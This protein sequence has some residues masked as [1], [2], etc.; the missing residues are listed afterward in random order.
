MFTLGRK[1]IKKFLTIITVLAVIILSLPLIITLLLTNRGIQNYVVDQAAAEA[2]KFLGTEVSIG[3][4]EYRMPASISLHDVYLEDLETD[5]L[6]YVKDLT[7][8]LSISALARKRISI[9]D[10][11]VG[12]AKFYL[13]TD[14]TGRTNLQF[15]I[16]ALQDTTQ[17]EVPV[18][19]FDA[20]DVQLTDCSVHIDNT[21]VEPRSDGLFD[22]AHIHIS[23]IN[24]LA[25]L[26]HAAA[27]SVNFVLEKFSLREKSGIRVSQLGFKTILGNN[28]IALEDFKL[29]L[30]Q[31]EIN[32]PVA[33]I[34]LDSL[35]QLAHPSLLAANATARFS[36][37]RTQIYG[38]DLAP[39][40]PEA[41]NM[42][43]GLNI[44][45][46]MEYEH[47][48][49]DIRLIDINYGTNTNL[50]MRAKLLKIA[51]AI[52]TGGINGLNQIS[53]LAFINNV[54]TDR[55][56]IENTVSDLT[57]KPF[58][59][60][61][62]IE[63]FTKAN[64]KGAVM[65]TLKSTKY[66]GTL[67]TNAG[68]IK[69]NAHIGHN[70]DTDAVSIDGNVGLDNFDFA[71]IFGD[72]MKIGKLT[73]NLNAN[74][75]YY[76]GKK[77]FATT[78]AGRIKSFEY[79][80]Y[81]F[82]DF[83]ID[84]IFNS[85]KAVAN[86]T[87]NDEN[88]NGNLYADLFFDGT[89]TNKLATLKL[90]S[91]TLKLGNMGFTPDYPTLNISADIDARAEFTSID[92]ITG[93]LF[94]DSICIGNDGLVYVIDSLDVN[95]SKHN[96][97]QHITVR[98]PL[99]EADVDGEYTLSTLFNNL[100]YQV[101]R[102]LTNLKPIETHKMRN[103]NRLDFRMKISPI[104]DIADIF[105]IKNTIEDTTYVI[106]SFSDYDDYFDLNVT[107][108]NITLGNNTMDSLKVFVNSH[109]GRLKAD[110]STIYKTF[111]DTTYLKLNAG[112]ENNVA[113]LN[114][115]F[116]NTVEKDFS[117]D[118]K[119]ST[120]FFKPKHSDANIELLCTVQESEIIMS[121]SLWT[122]NKGTIF[123]DEHKLI[124]K[125]LAFE[126]TDQYLR[127][128]GG[129]NRDI[130]GNFISVDL[131]GVDLS[132]ISEVAYMPD[133]KLLGIATGKV[134][135]GGA[136]NKDPIINADVEVKQFGLNRHP[137]ADVWAKAKFNPE[138]KRIELSGTVV[139][140]TRDT[141]Y[142]NGYVSPLEE[143]MLLECKINELPL[144]FIEPYLVTFS[145]EMDGIAN[146]TLS[147]GGKF[148]AIELW[149]D[150]YVHDAKL[151]IDYLGSTFHFADSVHIKRDRFIFK[152]I[153]IYDDHGNHGVIDGL[154]T[155][156]L[157]Q[158]FKFQIGF[159][160]D[161]TQVLN[162][163]AADFPDFYGTVYASG[164]AMIVG[165][166]SKVDI[167]VSAKP[168]EG[169]FFAVPLDSY[170]TA[171]DNQFI[172]FV[173]KD[174][175]RRSA[176]ALERRKKRFSEVAPNSI[177]NVDLTIEATPAVEAQ[178]ILD[179]H[180]GDVIRARGNGNIKVNVDQN[181]D[182]KLYGK[183][184]ITQGAYDFSLQGTI[185]K[186]FEVGENSSI[187]FDG[188]PM[189]GIL[190]ITAKYQTT[191]SLSDLLEESMLQDIKSN[192][193][194]VNCIARITG[195]LQEPQIK[196]DIELPGADDEV[197]RRVK[198]TI[199][200]EDMMTQ[201]MVFLLL[202]G[203]FYN[204][205]LASTSTSSIATSFATSTISSQLNYWMSQISKDVNFGVNYN[206]ANKDA[207]NNYSVA[208]NVSTNL[209]NNRLIINS[210]LGYRRQYGQ[211][212]FIGDFDVEYKLT[213]SGR[214][215]LKAYNK[216]NDMLYSTALYTQG[217]GI[218]YK[219]SF[220]TWENL[221]KTYKELLRKKTPEEKAA[222]KEKKEKEKAQKAK[223][224]AAK[225]ALREDRR[226]RH[227][228]YVANQ[229]AEKARQKEEKQR[230]KDEQKLQK[231]TEKEK[232]VTKK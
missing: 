190:N 111:L 150:A 114:F 149:G 166:E 156:H 135:I 221:G 12:G 81:T 127:L 188:D 155:H 71:K 193:V 214:F 224:K 122:I 230:L 133:I 186:K 67:S 36:T 60:P 48:N 100:Q 167:I 191:A 43:H 225:K 90:R 170:R 115:N 112:V 13:K 109:G 184:D 145:H 9:R 125:D 182:V 45:T 23:D 141:S 175:I 204:P 126:S 39:F 46:F 110:V 21:Q 174:T 118:I 11:E 54:G 229:K 179:A 14:S 41:G 228:E 124:V 15:I 212:N 162:T 73:F 79:N 171:T 183:F 37:Q 70:P 172:T 218:M 208:V 106:G 97:E 131:K 222:A 19:T 63:G 55:A 203:K 89:S 30:T 202:F 196:F 139:N 207:T 66:A 108:N 17:T 68:N 72:E 138:N 226:R 59:L 3:N 198:A 26:N 177:L 92:D 143:S 120:E 47:G 83:N 61:K 6:A 161:N 64:F 1:V 201:Q 7:A 28:R 113:D 69:T 95:I 107:T 136:L 157:F 10:V 2:G 53:L 164:K 151:G 134:V 76:I 29:K 227:K 22:P 200:T 216:T 104:S 195:N 86:V 103:S 165:D 205:Q 51:E 5:T 33:E 129:I 57:G 163:T 85:D 152:D 98:S 197:V 220:D 209:F 58:K 217:L 87:F 96:E 27:D 62:E 80:G 213:P 192:S 185:R 84:G 119:L 50:N 219:E 40:V 52:K 168:E 130:K 102:E 173:R 160:I 25:S 211:E 42:R 88:G 194:K 77:R 189:N 117:G 231:E 159:Q 154:V 32:I 215:R 206:D 65:G 153:D 38:R 74:G 35:S 232:R 169:S 44:R 128:K 144:G 210:N 8:R 93:Y 99:I 105:N 176:T 82:K 140:S 34:L 94:T 78:A 180:S 31:S 75:V 91:D 147:V 49:L 101:A 132:Y 56:D 187:S 18:L 20:P 178:I 142:V 24:I 16:D 223:I 199:N 121:D 146:G 158:K 116:I 137:I 123:F 148:D 4:I 181:A